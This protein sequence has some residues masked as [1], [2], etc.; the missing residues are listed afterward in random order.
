MTERDPIIIHVPHTVIE[1]FRPDER[2]PLDQRINQRGRADA[3][4]R[5]ENSGEP[6]PHESDDPFG[7]K[8]GERSGRYKKTQK[9]RGD[10]RLI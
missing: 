6:L 1:T 4:R 5:V 8:R 10:G 7:E 3:V 2:T 9:L